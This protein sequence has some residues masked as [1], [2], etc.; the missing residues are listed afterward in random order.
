M[1][2][3]ERRRGA[4]SS[5]GSGAPPVTPK[6]KAA[7]LLSSVLE[8]DAE[9]VVEE[10]EAGSASSSWWRWPLPPPGVSASTV[11]VVDAQ[12]PPLPPVATRDQ[13]GELA[14]VAAK[15]WWERSTGDGDV[16]AMV[17]APRMVSW[18]AGMASP[19]RIEGHFHLPCEP[20]TSTLLSVWL[21]GT[22]S[23]F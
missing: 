18:S 17:R 2:S 5:A 7:V 22:Y 20:T 6:A 8:D 19:G 13:E 21:V 12:V 23:A 16:T 1:R 11:V 4:A 14:R 10:Q 3:Q 15:P 9:T